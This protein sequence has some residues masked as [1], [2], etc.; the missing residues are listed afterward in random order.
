ML[1]EQFPTYQIS[2]IDRDSTARKGALE[3][4]LNDIREGKSQILIGTQMLA[5]G[6]HFRM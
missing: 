2:R 5:K 6:H 4:H 1:S 3:N